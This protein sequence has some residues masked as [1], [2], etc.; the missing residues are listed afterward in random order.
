MK[1]SLQ[2]I[3]LGSRH[4][5]LDIVFHLSLECVGH[6]FLRKFL[7]NTLS[8]D[9]C[10]NDCDGPTKFP[11]LSHSLAKVDGLCKSCLKIAL[12]QAAGFGGFLLSHSQMSSLK[13]IGNNEGMSLF[14][15]LSKRFHKHH[16]PIKQDPNTKTKLPSRCVQVGLFSSQIRNSTHLCGSG[17]LG[18]QG[19]VA[20]NSSSGLR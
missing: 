5:F 2:T 1:I 10:C 12:F 16:P 17:I 7:Q 14:P 13:H 15:A 4:W 6:M 20:W 19:L 8:H 3:K 9:L 18:S 11:A